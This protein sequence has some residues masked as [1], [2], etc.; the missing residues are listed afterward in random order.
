MET[1]RFDQSLDVFVSSILET[2]GADVLMAGTVLRDASGRLAFIASTALPDVATRRAAESLTS[3]LPAYCRDGRI[4]L[5]PDRPGVAALSSHGRSY[6]EEV[7]TPQGRIPI[8]VLEQRIIGQD[9]LT[10]PAASVAPPAA[11]RIVFASLKGGVGRSTALAVVAADLARRGR[12]VLVLDLDLEAPGI[13]AML[14]PPEAMPRFG[15]LDW[16]VERALGGVDRGF[17][18]DMLAP[19]D[20]GAGR[21]LVEV[22]PAVGATGQDHPAN[23]LA[24][25]AR[26]YLDQPSGEDEPQSFLGQTRRLV[27]DLGALKTYDAILIDARAG[28]NETTAAAILGLGAQVLLF[29][30]DT[31]QTFAGYRYLLAHLARF[32]RAE[33]DDWLYRLRMVHAKASADSGKQQAFRDRVYS[34]FQDYLYRDI[35]L[36]DQDGT[37]SPDT[38]LPEASLDAPEAPHFAW[39]VLRDSNYFEFDPL[40]EPAQLT[41][42]LYERTYQALIDGISADLSPED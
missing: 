22:A 14:L 28:L 34:L 23:V 1:T 4:V 16:Y 6:L 3:R 21:G 39:P 26:A 5:T 31:P 32:P 17:L 12:K 29:G 42:A 37:P 11:P 7:P 27:D 9:W 41:P 19:S 15:L 36:P 13:G 40:A 18:F 8:R 35:Q 38:T 20:L 2:L 30:E 10:V 24:K 33:E 25:I